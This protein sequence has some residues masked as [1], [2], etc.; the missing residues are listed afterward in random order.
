[1]KRKK[2]SINYR[3]EI[4]GL[5]AIAVLAVIIYHA[6][7]IIFQGFTL[8][9]GGY[10]GVD[11]FF[12]ISGYLIS[13]I[14][15]KEIQENGSFSFKNFYERRIRRILP[16]LFIVVLISFY[17]SYLFLLPT[18]FID[19]SKSSLSTLF[20]GSNYYFYFLNL[21]YSQ[22]TGFKKPLLHTWSLSIE[23][24]FYIFF[25]ITMF[26]AF[27]KFKKNFAFIL[28]FIFLTSFVLSIVQTEKNQ[29][30]SFYSL[31]SRIWEFCLGAIASVYFYRKKLNFT[32]SFKNL[33]SIFGLVLIFYSL[34]FLDHKYQHPSYFTLIPTVGTF[35]IILFS[36]K[37]NFVA[38]TLSSKILVW[39]GLISYSLYMWHYPV[40]AYAD[41]M[42][43]VGGYEIGKNI[44]TVIFFIFLIFS[45]STLS[46][47]FLEKPFRNKN[48]KFKNVSITLLLIL[49]ACVILN[50]YTLKKEGKINSENTKYETYIKNTMVNE[51]CKFY[52]NKKDNFFIDEELKNRYEDCKE[53]HKKFILII[54]DSH[55]GNLYNAISKTTNYDF[56]LG[57][58]KHGCRPSKHENCQFLGAEKFIE[59]EIKNIKEI[60]IT[61]KGSFFLTNTGD[62]NNENLTYVRKLPILKNEVSKTLRYLKKI[63]IL[64]PVIF[65]GPH[66]EPNIF[67]SKKNIKS[68]L[69]GDLEQFESN[70]NFDLIK[71][72]EYL[73]RQMKKNGIRYI[74]KIKQL[75]FNFKEDYVV[76]NKITFK[77]IGHWSDYGEYYFGKKLVKNNYLKNLEKDK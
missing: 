74:S 68:L 51:E 61:H 14:I 48:F 75:S 55:A 13:A 30:L 22:F 7:A 19:Y 67:L 18:D 21:D 63:N 34:L 4:D 42:Q 23:E 27:K 26:I 71:V 45:I 25:P 33:I 57:L 8:F 3:P 41:H 77:D 12:V 9:K 64:F 16:V 53:K 1:M 60:I 35:L 40:F 5:R 73:E 24:Q 6:P 58:I 46:Y 17:F 10:L 37:N 56:V 54:G 15:I 36:Y 39:I 2:I 49:L 29:I 69:N 52:S 66:I 59:T 50:F 11:I 32:N 31:H 72:D 43:F 65:V 62:P 76:N 38:K 20:F 28:W 70:L 44:F 47:F